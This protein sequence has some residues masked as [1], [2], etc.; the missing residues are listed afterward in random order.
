MRSVAVGNANLDS[1][2]L[3]FQRYKT[4]DEMDPLDLALLTTFHPLNEPVQFRENAVDEDKEVNT[5]A[6]V[7]D[8]CPEKKFEGFGSTKSSGR[9]RGKLREPVEVDD[10]FIER[11]LREL[12]EQR[13]SFVFSRFKKSSNFVSSDDSVK[14]ATK[15]DTGIKEKAKASGVTPE[16]VHNQKKLG[17]GR[18]RARKQQAD[19]EYGV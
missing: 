9:G 5:Q 16:A 19:T 7:D 17:R 8:S 10:F 18:G 1:S 12:S 6:N 13:S 2:Y 14:K 11:E 3:L 4:S 15:Y